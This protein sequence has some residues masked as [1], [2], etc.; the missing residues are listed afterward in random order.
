VY[1]VAWKLHRQKNGTKIKVLCFKEEIA[2]MK[3]TIPN[4]LSW[5]RVPV[6]ADLVAQ[7][8]S[9]IEERCRNKRCLFGRGDYRNTDNPKNL[10]RVFIRSD[11]VARRLN[12]VE[13]LL[14]DESCLF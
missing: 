5:I 12:I 10:S 9:T 3:A 7:K 14:K 8:L 2:G 4:F 13:E 1:P 11:S 6:R